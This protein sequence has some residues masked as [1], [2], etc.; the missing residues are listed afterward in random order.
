VLHLFLLTNGSGLTLCFFN[1]GQLMIT[2]EVENF[3]GFPEGIQGPELMERF[4]AQAKR[5]G[6]TGSSLRPAPLVSTVS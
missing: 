2:T 3:P 6:A 1:R 4:F 5:F